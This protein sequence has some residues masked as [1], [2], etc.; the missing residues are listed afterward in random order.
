MDRRV[1][2]RT[3]FHTVAL[4]GKNEQR[5]RMLAKCARICPTGGQCAVG[6]FG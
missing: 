4:D 6:R 1:S 5:T 3:A 2:G